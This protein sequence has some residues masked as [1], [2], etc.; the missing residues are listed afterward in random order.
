MNATSPLAPPPESQLRDDIARLMLGD[1][2]GPLSGDPHEELI[3]RPSMR[4]ILGTLA[5][6]RES[7]EPEQDEDLAG[8]DEDAD[9]EQG[10]TDSKEAARPVLLPSSMG[11]S[12]AVE[13][14][15]KALAVTVR[16]EPGQIGMEDAG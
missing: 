12:F 2:R 11:L 9:G 13:R 16:W 8:T 6:Q 7:L 4:Y 3:E 1:L 5:P 14:A 10:P 15:C